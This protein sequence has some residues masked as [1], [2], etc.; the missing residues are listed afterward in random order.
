[1]LPPEAALGRFPAVCLE[2]VSAAAFVHGQP[3]PVEASRK[4]A[5]G[6]VRVHAENGAMLG[7]GEGIEGGRIVK[8]LRI[9]HADLS[10]TR[11]LPV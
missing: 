5:T 9:L 8:P 3:V 2:P 6:L 11:V 10:G 4:S 7:V 1:M